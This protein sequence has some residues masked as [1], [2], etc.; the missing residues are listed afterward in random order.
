[1][2]FPG[3][4]IEDCT[5]VVNEEKRTVVCYYEGC[6]KMVYHTIR[7]TP[8]HEIYRY[9]YEH[10]PEMAYMKDRYAGVAKCAPDDEWDEEIGRHI[11][12]YRLCDK[13]MRSYFKRM[14]FFVN[15]VDRELNDFMYHLNDFG[16]KLTQVQNTRE[17]WITEHTK[18][19]KE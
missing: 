14:N 9:I 4:R 1:M 7:D 8:F 2:K 3:I 12:F 10:Y 5:F 6:R 11:A 13:V 19:I 18:P 15:Y 16:E 17:N